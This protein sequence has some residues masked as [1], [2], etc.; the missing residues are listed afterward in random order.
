M[1]MEGN[2]MILSLFMMVCISELD[3]AVGYPEMFSVTLCEQP[4]S[5]TTVDLGDYVAY[6]EWQDE[7]TE[8]ITLARSSDGRVIQHIYLGPFSDNLLIDYVTPEGTILGFTLKYMDMVDH[9]GDGYE[10]LRLLSAWGAA[11]GQETYVIWRFDP[12]T[13]TFQFFGVQ[14]HGEM[15]DVW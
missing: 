8:S 7:L 6:V 15:V 12:E 3:I 4:L 11:G 5:L 14:S 10:D 2:Q 9:D 13:E 1:N